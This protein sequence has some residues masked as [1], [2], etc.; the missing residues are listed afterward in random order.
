L[1]GKELFQRYLL[2]NADTDDLQ[3]FIQTFL[4]FETLSYD[5]NHQVR[6]DVQLGDLLDANAPKVAAEE[7]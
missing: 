6:T 5:G 7:P 4:D 1:W 3:N 2:E